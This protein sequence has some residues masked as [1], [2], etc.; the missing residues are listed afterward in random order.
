[1]VADA[2]NCRKRLS[3]LHCHTR[4]SKLH[5]E[6]ELLQD[7]AYRVLRQAICDGGLA[8]GAELNES[9]VAEMFQLTKA[10][11]RSA[12]A[13]LVHD[14]WLVVSTR[15][16]YAIRPI[17]LRDTKDI[18][19]LRKIVEPRAAF[20]AAGRASKEQL[21]QLNRN[22]A[23]PDTAEGTAA[24]ITGTEFF[25]ANK[26]F[27]VGIAE[28]A[29]NARLT[30]LIA[31]LHDECER[32]L[33]FGMNHLDWSLDWHH[34]HEEIIDALS[35]GDGGL[36]ESIALRQLVKSE[37]IVIDALLQGVEDTPIAMSMEK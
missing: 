10:P 30:S 7:T 21:Q 35:Q 34:G 19:G 29:G 25:K 2:I 6:K 3:C 12:L 26:A 27:H 31:S 16:G 28:L 1:M 14:G 15:R 24:S 5:P 23:S 36:A 13:R 33:Y 22:C 18:F 11:L 32:I 20:L 9:Q 8:P 37:Q 17:T 4:M